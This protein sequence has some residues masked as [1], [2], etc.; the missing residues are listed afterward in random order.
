MRLLVKHKSKT[1][2]EFIKD[3]RGLEND[4]WEFGVEVSTGVHTTLLALKP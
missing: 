4:K 1:C 2:T 3:V